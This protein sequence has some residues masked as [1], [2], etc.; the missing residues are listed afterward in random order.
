MDAY[1][2][3]RYFYGSYQIEKTNSVAATYSSKS[4]LNQG[5]LDEAYLTRPIASYK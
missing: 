4:N 1:V 3:Q 2:N 5:K